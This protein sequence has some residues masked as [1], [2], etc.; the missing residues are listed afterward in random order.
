MRS[1]VIRSVKT[2][3]TVHW[4]A[5]NAQDKELLEYVGLWWFCVASGGFPVAQLAVAYR[6]I[7]LRKPRQG[8][9]TGDGSYGYT[10]AGAPWRCGTRLGGGAPPR[11]STAPGSTTSSSSATATLTALGQFN[12]CRIHCHQRDRRC[13]YHCQT[14]KKKRVAPRCRSAS[15]LLDRPNT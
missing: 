1:S 9:G 6:W 14:K 4:D 15:T 5:L 10:R 13:E 2:S 8:H 12:E 11:C 7:S 3:G